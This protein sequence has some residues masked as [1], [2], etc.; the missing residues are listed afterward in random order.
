MGSVDSA[1][2]SKTIIT[3]LIG[4]GFVLAGVSLFQ[5]LLPLRAGLE[6]FS[7]TLVGFLGTVYCV[8]FIAGCLFGPKLVQSVGRS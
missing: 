4:A 1:K 2:T 3:I 8:G 7:T 6:S 5:T